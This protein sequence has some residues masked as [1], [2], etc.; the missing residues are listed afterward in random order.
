MGVFAR[1][2]DRGRR[3]GRDETVLGQRIRAEDG[4]GEE[5]VGNPWTRPVRKTEQMGVGLNVL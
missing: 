5:V 3:G 2:G 1:L 4:C